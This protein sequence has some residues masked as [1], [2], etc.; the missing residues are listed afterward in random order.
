MTTAFPPIT[1][2]F[3]GPDIHIQCGAQAFVPETAEEALGIVRNLLS[4]RGR[5]AG[6]EGLSPSPQGF[7]GPHPDS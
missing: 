7:K 1:I 5:L 3:L 2:T 6:A 4:V